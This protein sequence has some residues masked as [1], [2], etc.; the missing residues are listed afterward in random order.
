MNELLDWLRLQ[1]GGVRTY[2]QF[3]RR[4][5]RSALRNPSTPPWRD[6]LPIL[7]DVSRTPTMA[8]HS[9]STLPSALSTG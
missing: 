3:A 8:S 7:L 4:R 5:S 9:P 6:F 2:T 1:K